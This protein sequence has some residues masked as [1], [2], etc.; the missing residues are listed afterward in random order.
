M[1][2]GIYKLCRDLDVAAKAY[3]RAWCRSFA[4]KLIK[5][6]PVRELRD[7]IY[8]AVLQQ[9]IGTDELYIQPN[10]TFIAKETTSSAGYYASVERNNTPHYLSDTYMGT[11]FT[12]EICQS[13][14][15][16]V[17]LTIADYNDI[18]RT[19][20]CGPWAMIAC[21]A[22]YHFIRRI[23]LILSFEIMGLSTFEREITASK[24]DF[25]HQAR[26]VEH[27]NMIKRL[28][29]LKLFISIDAMKQGTSAKY[30]EA[31]VSPVYRLQAQGVKVTV[32]SNWS[33]PGINFDYSKPVSEWE[34]NIRTN[35]VF[36]SH[37][38]GP[39]VTI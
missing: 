17:L 36:V 34:E 11:Q 33:I 13:L 27:C 8:V 6:I 15:E 31:L 18:G 37:F 38:W 21:R 14:Y 5:A 39:N 32:S 9:G 10:R 28:D 25:E 4:Q 22:P 16:A 23:K 1:Y 35:S 7:S 3:S 12:D 2:S 19:L 30:E 26:C 29:G 24:A 20:T